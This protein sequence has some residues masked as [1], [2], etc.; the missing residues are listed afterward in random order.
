MREMV[1]INTRISKQLNEWLD[2]R[3]RETG[4]PKSTLVFLA[5]EQYMQQIEVMAKTHEWKAMLDQLEKIS[6]LD[7]LKE[8]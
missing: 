4:L 2:N 6:E 1:R 7:K 5:L 8:K 3:S